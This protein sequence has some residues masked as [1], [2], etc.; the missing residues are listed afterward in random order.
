LALYKVNVGFLVYGFACA[1]SATSIELK[2]NP[3]STAVP[4]VRQEQAKTSQTAFQSVSS[5]AALD[6][7]FQLAVLVR[8]P[9]EKNCKP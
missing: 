6:W 2:F 3:A 7:L 5:K 9:R 8:W 1:M 4:G